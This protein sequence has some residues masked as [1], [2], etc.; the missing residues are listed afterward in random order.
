MALGLLDDV[1]ALDTNVGLG[2]IVGTGGGCGDLVQNSEAG[3]V[4]GVYTT[5]NGVVGR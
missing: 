4:G 1:D 2:A 5:E 3:R